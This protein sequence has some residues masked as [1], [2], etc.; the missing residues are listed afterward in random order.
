MP[1]DLCRVFPGHD[2]RGGFYKRGC[3][4][5]TLFPGRTARCFLDIQ[6]DVGRRRPGRDTRSTVLAVYGKMD[7]GWRSGGRLCW[8][9]TCPGIAN[10]KLIERLCAGAGR[11]LPQRRSSPLSIDFP[12]PPKTR[13]TTLQTASGRA[14]AGCRW[15]HDR[16]LWFGSDARKQEPDGTVPTMV[17]SET[18]G[19]QLSWVIR[20]GIRWP[21][22]LGVTH[23]PA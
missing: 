12:M 17:L 18:R 9:A 23:S 22:R 20:G 15:F 4:G 5:K 3:Q 13:R 21:L 6:P 10:R 19:L 14:R 8:R 1:A 2:T 7:V 16:R 11:G